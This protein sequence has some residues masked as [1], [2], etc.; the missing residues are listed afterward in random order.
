ME[1]TVALIKPDAVERNL[2]GKIVE[3]IESNG[4][5]V[6]AMKLVSLTK[7]EAEGFYKVHAARPFYGELTEYIS[8]GPIVALVLRGENAIT[9]WRDLMGATNPENA[10]PG[11][12]RKDFAVNLE[13]NSVHGSDSP[14][15][16]SYELPFFFSAMEVVK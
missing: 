10:E 2:I 8:S 5:E 6:A 13:K 14:E 1:E 12:I 16:V 15:S 3:R 4:L 9:K 7:K 11:T